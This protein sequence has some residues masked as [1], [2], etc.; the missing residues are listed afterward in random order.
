MKVFVLEFISTV[1]GVQT[2][3]K[4]ILPGLSRNHTL[5]FLDP[6]GNDFDNSLSGFENIK[7]LRLPIKSRSSLGWNRGFLGRISII[8]QYG[9]EYMS[10]LKKLIKLIKSENA[11]MLYVSGK[12][13]LFFA[14]LIKKFTKMPYIY[15]SHGFAQAADIGFMYRKTISHA[16]KII[17]ISDATRRVLLE[18]KIDDKKITVVYNGVDVDKISAFSQ[19][20]NAENENF[21]VIFA[22]AVQPTK[23]VHTLA[24]AV[25]RLSRE[26]GGI[27]LDIF[28]EIPK[29][30]PKEYIEKLSDI[31]ASSG[32]AIRLCGY[33]DKVASEIAKRDLLVLPSQNEGLGMVL[34]EAMCLKKPVIGSNVGGIPEI[35]EDGKTGFLFEN[36]NADDLYEKIKALK[37]DRKLA[38]NM[39]ICGRER[40]EKLYSLKVQVDHIDGVIKSMKDA[41]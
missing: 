18:R 39:G 23:G 8:F 36:K 10:Y 17:C 27:S 19:P 38:E 41:D 2:V 11:D 14:Y 31:A 13:E 7:V 35:I 33:S 24:E 4:N 37:N 40:V 26:E 5:C 16:D 9:F 32:G 29:A 25:L 15:H 34:L 28:G 21:R 30:V 3:Y 12:K 6:Y 1:G 20:K 22:G